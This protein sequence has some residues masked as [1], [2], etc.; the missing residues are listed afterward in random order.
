MFESIAVIALGLGV[1]RFLNVVIHRMPRDESIVSP[2]RSCPVCKASIRWYQNIPLFSFIFLKGKCA[3]CGAKISYRY[4]LVEFLTAILFFF[5]YR[6]MFLETG[7]NFH[8]AVAQFRI[9]TFVAIGVSVIFIDLDHRII[10]NELSLGGWILGAMTC[11]WD[12]RSGPTSLL[13]ASVAGFG[14]FYLF[15]LG[16]EKMTGRV[17]LGGGDIKFMGTIGIFLGVGGIWAS[18]VL[19]SVL[20]SFIGIGYAWFQQRNQVEKN[21]L[22]VSLP[23][24]PFLVFGAFVELFFEV[25]KWLNI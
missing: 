20:G 15:A 22:K 12:F 25:S 1:G 21:L 3:H 8:T 7:I 24:G 5:S 10:P 9:W 2:G 16:Y 17:G 4:P 11:F 23:Y 18:L 6:G 14:F 19:S 13:I